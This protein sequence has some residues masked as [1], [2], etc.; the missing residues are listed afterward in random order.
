METPSFSPKDDLEHD[1]EVKKMVVAVVPLL[2]AGT[3]ALVVFLAALPILYYFTSDLNK[4]FTT[5]AQ[6]NPTVAANA[7]AHASTQGGFWQAPE[8]STAA[9]DLKAQIEYGRDLIV[10]TAK[11]LG[12]KGSVLQISNGMNCQNCHLDAGTKIFGN[13]YSSVAALY[14]K[15]RERSNSEETIEKRVNDCFER[16]LNG[17]PLA[18]ESKEMQAIKAYLLFLGSNVEKGKEAKGAGLKEIALL[19]RPA[20]PIKGKEIYVAKCQSCHQ[21]NGEGLLNPDGVEYAFPPLWGKNSYNDAAGLY[22][23]SNFAKYVKF[24]MP[25]GVSYQNPILTDEEAWDV[26]AFVNSQP[27]PHKE[28]PNDFPNL[29]FKPFDAPFAPYADNFSEAQHKYGAY[30]EIIKAQKELQQQKK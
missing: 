14:P 11:Y 30:Q 17:K 21:A 15:F 27:H 18:E 20:D 1:L 6:T 22:R 29:A 4:T 24:N 19:D 12:P 9:P 7:A 28:T 23:L 13:N 10:H 25:L 2:L 26:A 5:Y 16:S 8:L 3:V